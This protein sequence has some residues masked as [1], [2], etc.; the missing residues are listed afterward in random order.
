MYELNKK[1]FITKELEESEVEAEIAPR[2]KEIDGLKKEESGVMEEINEKV[3]E[4]RTMCYY[5]GE[6]Y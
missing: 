6:E 2:V 5:E 4:L 3:E 1:R